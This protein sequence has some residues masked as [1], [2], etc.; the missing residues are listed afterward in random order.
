MPRT[1]N[2][3]PIAR[4]ALE[5]LNAIGVRV[6]LMECVVNPKTNRQTLFGE[7]QFPCG[8][9]IKFRTSPPGVPFHLICTREREGD[10]GPNIRL[11]N[12]YRVPHLLSTIQTRLLF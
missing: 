2:N 3:T 6:V 7:A 10:G 12:K 8:D 1:A 11:L 9:L 4:I 5:S